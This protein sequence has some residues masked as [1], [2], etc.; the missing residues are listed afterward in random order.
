MVSN[1]LHSKVA[2]TQQ[3]VLVPHGGQK[4]TLSCTS[5]SLSHQRLGGCA[6]NPNAGKTKYRRFLIC[7]FSFFHFSPYCERRI[8]ECQLSLS[9]TR[10]GVLYDPKT[11]EGIL[12]LRDAPT[13]SCPIVPSLLPL[14]DLTSMT[15]LRNKKEHLSPGIYHPGCTRHSTGTG[16]F[17]TWV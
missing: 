16:I 14:Q 10:P 17:F 5:S 1:I 15:L 9:P 4:N 7:S 2:A 13:Y 6:V 12:S 3:S 8:K 11:T